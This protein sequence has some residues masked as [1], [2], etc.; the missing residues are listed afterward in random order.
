[1]LRPVIW[2]VAIN[3]GILFADITGLRSLM[4][5]SDLLAWP[6]W[7]I[8]CKLTLAKHVSVSGCLICSLVFYS[9]V[10][11]LAILAV[12]YARSYRERRGAL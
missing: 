3:A 12:Q 10:A 8:V 11:W 9:I 4:K 7:V 1:V 2:S 6:P 5:V